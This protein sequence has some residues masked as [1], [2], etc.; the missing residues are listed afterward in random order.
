MK[1]HHIPARRMFEEPKSRRRPRI[2]RSLSE[3]V[4]EKR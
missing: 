2:I 4:P 1:A 3:L